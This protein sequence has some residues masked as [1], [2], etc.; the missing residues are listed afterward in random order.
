M[1]RTNQKCLSCNFLINKIKDYKI[2]IIKHSIF[3]D[4]RESFISYKQRRY[5]CSISNKSFIEQNPF[6]NNNDKGSKYLYL[7]FYLL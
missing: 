2:K 4:E 7:I 3:N 1:K 5:F 6:V